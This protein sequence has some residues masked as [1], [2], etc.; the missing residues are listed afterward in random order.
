MSA[1]ETTMRAV[2]C[3]QTDEMNAAA[4]AGWAPA[5]RRH[6][7]GWLLLANV[8][9]L[10]LATELLWPTVGDLL[11]PLTY[12]RWMPLHLNWQLYGW[13]AL[14]LVGALMAGFL[15][16]ALAPVVTRQVRV[17][18]GLWSFALAL[19]GVSWLAGVTSGKLFLD[20]YGWARPL[21]PLAMI[22]LWTLLAAHL[23][24]GWRGFSNAERVLR[25][26]LLAGLVLVPSLLYAAAGREMYPPVNPH[27]GGATGTSLLGSTLGVVGVFLLLPS[28]LRVPRVVGGGSG[29]ATWLLWGASAGVFAI[30][31]HGHASHHEAAQIVALGLLLAW[32]PL[33]IQFARQYQWRESARLWLQAA[34][35]WWAAL[36]LSGWILF[37]PGLSERLKFTN[38]LVSHAHLA[39]AGLVTSVNFALLNQLQAKLPLRRGFWWWQVACIV[40]VL[41]L[42]IAGWFEGE[43]EVVV[44]GSQSWLDLAYVGR[45]L[46]GLAM[47]YGS[48]LSWKETLA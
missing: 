17:V 46:A 14:P 10:L 43:A 35:G 23:W 41:V 44:F 29:R 1:T 21:L 48:W 25:A 39:M 4:A 47:V 37:L 38:A 18:L 9:G 22:A 2:L 8:V 3:P 28:L 12:G 26:G 16:Q 13:C 32:I 5:V 24:W 31:T 7:I 34:A 45:W 27:S 15:P 36:V 11:A 30:Q 42:L 33:L 40:H 20:W 19:G 6:A